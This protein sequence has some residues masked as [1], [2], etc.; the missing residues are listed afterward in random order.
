MPRLNTVKIPVQCGKPFPDGG[1]ASTP[2]LASL[3]RVWHIFL[4]ISGMKEK[5]TPE[6]TTGRQAEAGGQPDLAIRL[7]EKEIAANCKNLL[8][9]QRLLVLYRRQKKYKQELAVLT[10]GIHCLEEQ[11]AEHKDTLFSKKP[12]RNKIMR[13]SKALAQ[14]IGLLD[15]KGK[16]LLPPQPLEKW[17]HREKLVRKKMQVKT[18]K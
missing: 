2:K 12:Q 1:G 18:T 6:F 9:Y 16:E 8:P 13:L 11:L 5:Q 4:G 14:K 10:K 15:K 17:I 7:Y 3:E